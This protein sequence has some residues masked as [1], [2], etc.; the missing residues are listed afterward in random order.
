MTNAT[1]NNSSAS[2]QILSNGSTIDSTNH[3][4]QLMAN[5]CYILNGS[6]N[7]N[8]NCN[9]CINNTSVY[10]G[11]LNTYN[12]Q[13]F[14]YIRINDSFASGI[15][16]CFA[17]TNDGF[18]DITQGTASGVLNSY[19]TITN[20]F[21]NYTAGSWGLVNITG[22]RSQTYIS[23]TNT[24]ASLGN[25]CMV[26]CTEG[27]VISDSQDETLY[28]TTI[29]QYGGNQ[30]STYIASTDETVNLDETYKIIIAKTTTTGCTFNLPATPIQ[31]QLY[32][33]YAFDANATST[34]VGNGNNIGDG[35]LSNPTYP[36]L[37]STVKY[38]R[39]VFDAV[40][41]LWIILIAQ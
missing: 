1:S 24:T 7:A 33:F 6:Y 38:V 36:F 35:L 28:T 30:Y 32:E 14:Q 25:N 10:C 2:G 5:N 18:V 37:G 11:T 16:N 19:F 40:D 8:F 13:S 4:V 23:N 3:A 27:L 26:A 22:K 39:L 12:N 15:Y 20:T 29:R 17:D 41:S 21:P 34:I 9:N 31:G